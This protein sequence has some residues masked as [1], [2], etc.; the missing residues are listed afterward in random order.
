MVRSA[1]GGGPA[2]DGEGE[3][4][5]QDV[6]EGLPRISLMLVPVLDET[7][8]AAVTARVRA[9]IAEATRAGFRDALGE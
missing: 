8:L 9:A 7:E 3:V 1:W 5:A 2:G 6:P 4:P